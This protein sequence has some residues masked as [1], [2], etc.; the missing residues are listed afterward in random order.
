MVSKAKSGVLLQYW[1]LNSPPATPPALF[2]EG[3]F[4]IGSPELFAQLALNLD[5]PDLCLLSS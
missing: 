1:G 2:C 5:P 4:E 3:F